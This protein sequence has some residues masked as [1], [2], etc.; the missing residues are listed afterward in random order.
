MSMNKRVV[1]G[2]RNSSRSGML[3]KINDHFFPDKEDVV[4]EYV[5]LKGDIT[6][7][8]CADAIEAILSINYPTFEQDEEGFNVEVPQPDVINLMITSVGGDMT[9]AFALI[10]VIR[11]SRI[12][13]RT[14]V[15]GEAASA[16]LCILMAGH[17]RV[18]TPYS[19]LMSH[20]FSSGVEGSYHDIINAAD[21]FKAYHEKMLAF[22]VECTGLDVKFIKK[23]LLVDRDHY[24]SPEKA[25]SY[26]M[27]DL[28][29][30]LE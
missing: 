1:F 18:A 6:V 23:F 2:C 27:V 10:N 9:G 26:N 16:G 8:S 17:Q 25:L 19:G 12:P 22:Y 3:T 15:L 30:T 4:Q 28:V 21:A 20:S 29:E 5:Y 7:E 24:F 14:I 11:G 13:V